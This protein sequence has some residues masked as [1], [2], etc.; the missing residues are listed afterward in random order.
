MLQKSAFTRYTAFH[1]VDFYKVI[2]LVIGNYKVIGLVINYYTLQ[3]DPPP[4]YQLTIFATL[5]KTNTKTT[6]QTPLSNLYLS[7]TS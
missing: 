4:H 3:D 2:G 7:L 6:N 1:L 5:V